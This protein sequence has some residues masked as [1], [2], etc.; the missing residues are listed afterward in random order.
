MWLLAC[1]FVTD[2]RVFLLHPDAKGM[3]KKLAM[4]LPG[5]STKKPNIDGV[6]C[7]PFWP[8]GV[9]HS[10]KEVEAPY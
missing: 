6:K 8:S 9:K 5:Y 4:R 2:G 7:V 1:I 10:E 3:Q